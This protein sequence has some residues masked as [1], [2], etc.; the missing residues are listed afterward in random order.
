MEIAD[1]EPVSN[2][3]QPSQNT[4][5]ITIA[6]TNQ[7]E[8]NLIQICLNLEPENSTWYQSLTTYLETFCLLLLLLSSQNSLPLIY[9]HFLFTL[10]H[11]P[12][13]QT[14]LVF[15]ICHG[16]L[17]H[18]IRS[19]LWWFLVVKSV[20]CHAICPVAVR[21]VLFHAIHISAPSDL[22]VH[23]CIFTFPV[24]LKLAFSIITASSFLIAAAHLPHFF[25][26]IGRLLFF[27]DSISF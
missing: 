25:F 24:W 6:N 20:L 3:E 27:K 14:L 8:P 1:T 16:N 19:A 13:L 18:A 10:S 15:S 2:A 4:N 7:E 12:S 11:F 9:L 5:P 21:T 26:Q 17:F 22:V 23:H